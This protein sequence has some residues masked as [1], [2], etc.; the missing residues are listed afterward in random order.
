MRLKT[1]AYEYWSE[2]VD[3]IDDFWSKDHPIINRSLFDW[4]YKGF[5]HNSNFELFKILLIDGK[6]EGFR[7]VIPGLYHVPNSNL[8][9]EGGT[10]SM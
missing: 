9:H 1:L 10:F 5:G 2:F 4:Q 7:G 6:M 3:L 8:I